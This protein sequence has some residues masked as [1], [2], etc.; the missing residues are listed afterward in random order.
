MVCLLKIR[1]LQDQ[2]SAIERK[3]ADFI[4]DNS[5]L[6]RDYSSQQLADAVGVSQSSVVK[7][8]QKVGYKGYPDFKLAVSEALVAQSNLSREEQSD[9]K[10]TPLAEVEQFQLQL[11]ASYRTVLEINEAKTLARATELLDKADKILLVGFGGSG[12]VAADFAFRLRQLGKT[13][14]YHPDPAV[15]MQYSAQLSEQSVFFAI[16]QSGE[17]QDV[18][19]LARQLKSQKVQL[20][21]LTSFKT[22]PLSLLV[23]TPLYVLAGDSSSRLDPL[24]EQLGA[25]HLCHLL[26]LQLSKITAN[27]KVLEHSQRLLQQLAQR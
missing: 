25:Q 4:L 2:M 18:L 9:T 10:K 16:S 24:L 14:C 11:Q 12:L 3:L 23:Q 13:V 20:M 17:N 15:Q 8:C 19:R 22:N 7:F 21:S 1:G 5:H 6:L 26:Y 27:A